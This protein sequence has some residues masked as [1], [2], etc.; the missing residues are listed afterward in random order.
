VA[1]KNK[2]SSCASK[3]IFDKSGR[4]EPVEIKN[5]AT[6]RESRISFFF[7]INFIGAS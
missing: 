2:K 3:S 6:C 5:C 4:V 1:D 7:V